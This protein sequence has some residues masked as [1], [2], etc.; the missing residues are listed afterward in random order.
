MLTKEQILTLLASKGLTDSSSDSEINSVLAS[1][2]LSEDAIADSFLLLRQ[3][4]RIDSR[5]NTMSMDSVLFTDKKLSPEMVSS[6]LHI[7]ILLKLKSENNEN[8]TQVSIFRLD[9]GSISPVVISVVC[10]VIFAALLG[11]SILY[12]LEIGPFYVST[13][14]SL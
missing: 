6:L 12:L 1:E 14:I 10:A 13:P 8:G 5:I 9:D 4:N 3:D 7:D 11:F 2:G